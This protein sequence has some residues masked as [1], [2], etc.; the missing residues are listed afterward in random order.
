MA[1]EFT[2]EKGW[3]QG[4]YDLI[5]PEKYIG[6]KNKIVYRSAWEK[7]MHKF[8]DNNPNIIQWCS[9]PFA[10]PYVKPTDGEVHRYFPDYY[11]KYKDKYGKI[12][13]EI[14]EV[15]PRSQRILREGASR[16]EVV[17]YYVNQAKWKYAKAWCDAHGLTFS[18]MSER[19]DAS[20]RHNFRKRK[21]R[22]IRARR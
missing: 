1:I 2:H 18:V 9:E 11:I 12:H 19:P 5:H 16:A 10:I 14:V 13:E 6:D 8:L 20:N 22:K 4:L 21:I 3:K 7:E 15:K 17:D